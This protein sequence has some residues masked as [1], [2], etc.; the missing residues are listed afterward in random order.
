MNVIGNSDTC[1]KMCGKSNR[2]LP[3]SVENILLDG[4][5][6]PSAEEN[7]AP[8]PDDGDISDNVEDL[9]RELIAERARNRD[10][11][12]TISDILE[13]MEDMK[14]NIMRNEEKITLNQDSVYLLSRDIDDL[15]DD[16]VV[17]AADVER[18]IGHIWNLVWRAVLLGHSLLHHHLRQHHLFCF[19]QHELR[20]QPTE[21]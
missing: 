9:Q 14:K 16:V 7:P 2:S 10:L 18:N 11:N 5:K 20:L 4:K 1:H 6:L 19:K 17:V 21:Q 3:F 8:N 13:E 12:Q 15:Q